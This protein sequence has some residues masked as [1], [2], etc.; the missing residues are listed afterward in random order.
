M[1]AP[2][3][4][5]DSPLSWLQFGRPTGEFYRACRIAGLDV[6]AARQR[7]G[8]VIEYATIRWVELHRLLIGVDGL[9]PPPRADEDEPQ[10]PP[11][12]SLPRFELDRSSHHRHG[13]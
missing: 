2:Q 13:S 7:E 8:Q 9:T 5:P 3:R 11:V 10:R 12:G 1:G 6:G 4:P